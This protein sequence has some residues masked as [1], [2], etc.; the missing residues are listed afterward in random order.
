MFFNVNDVVV[1]AITGDY[2]QSGAGL[3]WLDEDL[4]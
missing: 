4:P 1:L 2:E 3:P